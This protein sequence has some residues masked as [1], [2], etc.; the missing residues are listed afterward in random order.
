MECTIFDFR[1]AKMFNEIA[2]YRRKKRIGKREKI[3]RTSSE[4]NGI[5][6]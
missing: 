5:T 6:Q 1:C 2:N 3:F 4:A